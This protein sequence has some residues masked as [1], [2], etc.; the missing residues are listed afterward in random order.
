[1]TF[2]LLAL[3]SWGGFELFTHLV[4]VMANMGKQPKT[5]TTLL[6]VLLCGPAVW[7]FV[8]VVFCLVLHIHFEEKRAIKKWMDKPENQEYTKTE[9]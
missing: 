7:L 4:I 2:L 6:L 3:W 1:M 8:G 5:L 9:S